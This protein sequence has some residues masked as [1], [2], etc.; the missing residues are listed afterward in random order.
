MPVIDAYGIFEG[1][2]LARCSKMA[3]LYYPRLLLAGNGFGRVRIDYRII[4]AAIFPNWTPDMIPTE[5][6]LMGFISEYHTHRLIFLYESGGQTWGQWDAKKGTFGKYQTQLDLRSPEPPA[7]EFEKWVAENRD[8]SKKRSRVTTPPAMSGDL[9]SANLRNGLEK[10]GDGV[11]VG[12]GLRFEVLGVGIGDGDLERESQNSPSPENSPIPQEP[13]PEPEA[14]EH[15]IPEDSDLKII[16]IARAHP[17]FEKPSETEK[18]IAFQLDRGIGPGPPGAGLVGRF[19]DPH[20]AL[21]YLLERTRLYKR[22]T[23][24]WPP[25][26][27]DYI[28]SSARWFASGCYDEDEKNWERRIEKHQGNGARG[29]GGAYHSGEKGKYDDPPD[30]SF[31]V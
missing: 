8:N 26:Q 15:S 29:K 9:F 22:I 30:Y 12:V 28:V 13:A 21:E 6:E 25:G 27:Q 17:R 14:P 10:V 3:Q 23:D 4:S 18:A 31:A 16:E 7:E 20:K 1:E 19:G 2:R 24:L 5:Y 11:G